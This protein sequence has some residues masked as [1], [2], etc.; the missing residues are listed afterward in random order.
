MFYL[1]SFCQECKKYQELRTIVCLTRQHTLTRRHFLGATVAALT[2]LFVESFARS[3]EIPQ[4]V[5]ELWAGFDELDRTTPLET[6]ILKAWEQDGVVCRIV[7]YQ[8][9]VFKGAPAKVAAFYAFPKGG[10]KLPALL[11]DAW[12]RPVGRRSTAW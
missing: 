3:A 12:R 10:T 9:G 6:E 7:R 1:P 8:V 11:A 5:A 2:L 4:T